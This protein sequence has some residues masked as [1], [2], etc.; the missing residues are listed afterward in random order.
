[1]YFL[2][3][4]LCLR[5]GVLCSRHETF[6]PC[7]DPTLHASLLILSYSPLNAMTIRGIKLNHEYFENDRPLIPGSTTIIHIAQWQ[8]A[9]AKKNQAIFDH[10]IEADFS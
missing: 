2:I 3:D 6:V 10:G 1:M 7:T 4:S 5:F 8:V 9:G